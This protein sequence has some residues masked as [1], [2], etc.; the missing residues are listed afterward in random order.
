MNQLNIPQR[1]I[2]YPN[3]NAPSPEQVQRCKMALVRG[4]GSHSVSEL[5][6]I[7]RSR[8]RIVSLIMAGGCL[9]FFVKNLLDPEHALAACPVERFLHGTLLAVLTALA[10]L[11][12]TRWPLSIRRLRL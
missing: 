6:C 11:L 9:V 10:A 12:W 2:E 1:T 5:Q 3:S 7:L 4:S 8:L